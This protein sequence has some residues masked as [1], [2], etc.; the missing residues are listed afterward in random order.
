MKRELEEEFSDKTKTEVWSDAYEAVRS[1]YEELVLRWKEEL[2][3]LLVYVRAP[4]ITH[5]IVHPPLVRIGHR[6]IIRQ[7][8]M[9][10]TIY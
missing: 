7:D 10:F 1:Y 5:P 8:Q 3:T 9:F 6:D 4:P 2:D